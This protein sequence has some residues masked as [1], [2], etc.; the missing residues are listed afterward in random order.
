MADFRAFDDCKASWAR[1]SNATMFF[2]YSLVSKLNR[3]SGFSLFLKAEVQS[4]DLA[5][6]LLRLRFFEG[7]LVMTKAGNLS[8]LDFFCFELVA[9]LH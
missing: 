5:T 7:L 3:F 2:V 9:V 4:I 6:F 1:F 8:F